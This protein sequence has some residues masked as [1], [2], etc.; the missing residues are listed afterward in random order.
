MEVCQ[1][2]INVPNVLRRKL[3]IREIVEQYWDL[4]ATPRRSTMFT[5]S[6]ISENELEKDKLAEFTVADKQEELYNYVNRPRR[7]IVEVLNDF[8]HAT[9]KL[10]VDLLFEIMQPIKPR[11]FSIASSPSYSKNEMHIL[12][13][14][15]QYKT[16]L[17]EP[18]YGLGSNWLAGNFFF[19]TFQ[20]V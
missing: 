7:N 1:G 17:V 4:N 3:S 15:V 6:Q 20:I 13:A 11:A 5:L 8:P 14:V 9:S 12:V 16:K 19:L 2:E 10:N 18:R